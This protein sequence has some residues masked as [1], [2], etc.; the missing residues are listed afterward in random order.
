MSTDVRHGF[1]AD[2]IV[3]FQGVN[4][5]TEVNDREFKIDVPSPFT[6]TIGD[7]SKFGNYEGGGMVIEVKKPAIVDFVRIISNI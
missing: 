4:G 7:T 3:T 6:I 2:S 5:M 1:E